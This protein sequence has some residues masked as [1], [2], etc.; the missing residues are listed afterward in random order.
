MKILAELKRRNVINMAGLYLVGAWLVVQVAATLLPVFEA[1]EWVMRV[2]VGLLALG[3]LAALV[4]SW[5]FELTPDGFRRDSDVAAS[6]SIAPQTARKMN[7]LIVAGLVLV[8][9]LMA[10]ERFWPQTATPSTAAISTTDTARSGAIE[11][12]A[13][14]AFQNR[15]ADADS[16]Y[17]SDGLAESLIYRL[18]QLPNLKV[19]PSSSIF[20]YKGKDLDPV[21]IGAELGVSSVM[22]GRLVQRGDEL[23]ISVELLDVRNNTLLWGEQFNRN[24]SELLGTQR[25]IAATITEKLK[26]ELSGDSEQKLRKKYTDSAKAYEHYLKGRFFWNKRDQENLGKAIEQFKAAIAEDPAY[27]L[28]YVGLADSYV[29]LPYYSS[30]P[31]TEALP[32]AKDY[33][34]RA[35]EIDDSLGEAHASLGYYH[36]NA[37]NWPAAEAAFKRAIELNPGY[38]TAHQ[39]FGLYLMTVNRF[40]EA[41]V[42]LKRAQELEPLSH[43]I[44]NNLVELHTRRGN[45][46]AA[47]E[48]SERAIQLDP[49]W[50]FV[51]FS[52]ALLFSKQ[53]RHEEALV[54]AEKSVALSQRQSVPLGVLGYVHARAGRQADAL[55][56]AAELQE[57]SLR[58]EAVGLDIARVHA[59]LG[60]KDEAFAWLEMEYQARNQK[61]PVWLALVYFDPLRDDPRYQGLLE[62]LGLPPQGTARP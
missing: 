54:E 27:A 19:S 48:Q 53:G 9:V 46:E 43:V 3:F 35:L 47:L 6:D 22:S 17:L 11:S 58:N 26:L 40:D 55:R 56:V 20:R 33:L 52:R 31:S 42:S 21:T 44:H 28:A 59:G 49:D 37:W 34:A 25:E 61:L 23:I 8:I 57:R 16:E 1:P 18:A 24:L 36:L 41:E 45:L 15:S 39:W 14:L 12:I 7:R 30:I 38:A 32:P 13:V 51:R 10:V 4:F 62:R 50:Y 2:L 29:V 60:D 5:M